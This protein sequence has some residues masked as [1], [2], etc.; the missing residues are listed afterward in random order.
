LQANAS[1]RTSFLLSVLGISA[2]LALV[3]GAVGLY[4]VTSYLV[5]LRTREI[6]VRMA[7]GASASDVR[8]LVLGRALRDAGVGVV[9]GLIGALFVGRMIAASI[10]GVAPVDPTALLAASMLLLATSIVATWLPARRA[11]RLDPAS[12]LRAD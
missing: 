1:A 6:G 4:G 5:G 12:T 2:L 3:I 7:L 11:S 8:R 9:V 10:Y